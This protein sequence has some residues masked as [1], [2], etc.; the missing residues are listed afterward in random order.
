MKE[1]FTSTWFIALMFALTT[2]TRGITTIIGIVLLIKQ[3]NDR[4]GL[5]KKYGEINSLDQVIADKDHVIADKDY[6]ITELEEE[7]SNKEGEIS[8]LEESLS[9][10]IKEHKQ[11]IADMNKEKDLLESELKCKHYNFSD[12]DALSSEECKNKLALLKT[13]E[14]ALIKNNNALI[15]HAEAQ[16]SKK[17]ITNNEKQILRCFSAECDNVLLNLT[18][19]NIDSSR[20]KITRSFESLNRIFSVDGME[21][22]N[23]MLDYKL[24]E[25]DLV[26]TFSLKKEQEKEI[27]TAIK[28][29]MREEAKAQRELENKKKQ[30]QKDQTQCNNEVKK[31]MMYMQKTNNDIEKKLYVDKIHELEE[32]IKELEKEQTSVAEREANAK[33]GYVYVISNIGSFGKD[34]YKI[35]MTRRLE[36]MDRINELSSASVPFAFDVHAMIFS[37]DAPELESKLHQI[38]DKNRVNRINTRKEFFHVSLDKIEEAVKDNFDNTVE[39]TRIPAAKEYNESMRMIESESVVQ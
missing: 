9:Q 34:I 3:Y 25:L 13:E 14:S 4:K 8:T 10:Q 18:V 16:S 17:V 19:K 30:L 21:L 37:T 28:E 15:E 20:S 29:Q 39:F 32:K 36:P 38:F 11:K 23:Q 2:P 35:G 12:Y 27:Q 5:I 26:Y 6:Y 1:T 22:S 33:A 7:I 24:K 31:L